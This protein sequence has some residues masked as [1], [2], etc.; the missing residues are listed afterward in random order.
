[1]TAT[2]RT[3]IPRITS[4]MIM[5]VRFPANLVSD[6]PILPGPIL[7]RLK[8]ALE[9]GLQVTSHHAVVTERLLQHDT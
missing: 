2:I 8:P 3:K 7:E 1:M 4:V 9:G 5:G 6:Q